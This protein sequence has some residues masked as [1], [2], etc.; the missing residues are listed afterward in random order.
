MVALGLVSVRAAAQTPE[1]QPLAEEK[2]AEG[3]DW[4]PLGEADEPDEP[5]P[6]S[7]DDPGYGPTGSP[8]RPAELPPPT[9]AEDADP[10]DP[11]DGNDEP[12]VIAWMRK[13]WKPL[14]L[15]RHVRAE[16]DVGLFDAANVYT[17]DVVAQ[18]GF[19]E[20][21]AFLDI[22]IP[23]GLA[24]PEAGDDKAVVGNIVIGGHGGDVLAATSNKLALWGGLLV[25]IPT[26]V[27]LDDRSP[28]A[29]GALAISSALR[30]GIE[31]HRFAPFNVPIRANVGLAYQIYPLV[32]YRF[33]MAGA[34][35][36]S[37]LD[38][39]E[40]GG[41]PAVRGF[42]EFVNDLEVL[43]PW[44][45][46]AGVRLQAWVDGTQYDGGLFGNA[47]D[48]DQLAVEP[49]I[50]YRPPFSGPANIPVFARLGFLLPVDDGGFSNLLGGLNGDPTS[51]YFVLRATVG[52]RF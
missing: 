35:W 26:S 51:N 44:G 9:N 24:S 3:E 15:T 49:Y 16:M 7:G 22:D 41:A 12:E 27:D 39:A 50:M 14:A 40:R 32:Y 17:W 19:D 29:R 13:D 21:P 30:A 4:K 37:T 2:D 8:Y 52:G 45:P 28:L 48:R 6:P 46:G 38:E 5:P 33:E 42:V 1:P 34:A 47:F 10:D 36:V 11:N 23:I 43:S 31:S 20:V 18:L 25:A